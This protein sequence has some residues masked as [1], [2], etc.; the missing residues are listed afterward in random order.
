M[1]IYQNKQIMTNAAAKSRRT[2]H[3]SSTGCNCSRSFVASSSRRLLCLPMPMLLLVLIKTILAALFPR[4]IPQLS[5]TAATGM[6]G[7]EGEH[8]R[9][10]VRLSSWPGAA[11]E[12]FHAR[13]KGERINYALLT[14]RQWLR[15]QRYAK[16]LCNIS[17]QRRTQ[18]NCSA[19]RNGLLI[20]ASCT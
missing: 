18:T 6:G 4:E 3:T 13:Q 19:C 20:V 5:Q 10:H 1:A 11:P 2:L 8:S 7:G 9:C 14:S 12:P 17:W 15:Y 16:T